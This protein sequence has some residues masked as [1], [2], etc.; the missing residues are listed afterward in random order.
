MGLGMPAAQ[1]GAVSALLLL[2]ARLLTT[3]VLPLSAVLALGEGGGEHGHWGR[4]L[5]QSLVVWW[6]W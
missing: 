2:A 4:A 5:A 6:W 3:V 1:A